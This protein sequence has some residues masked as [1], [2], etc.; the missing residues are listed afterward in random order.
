LYANFCKVLLIHAV[1]AQLKAW[2]CG[3]SLAGTVGSNSAGGI[4]SVSYECCVL[5][6]R[7]LCVGLISRPEE[8][9]RLWCV[10]V[11]SWSLDNAETKAHQRLLRRGGK[12]LLIQVCYKET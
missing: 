8:S 3:R 7:D 2:A 12:N 1:A 11:W 5:S 4:M 10:W 6:G 9:Y